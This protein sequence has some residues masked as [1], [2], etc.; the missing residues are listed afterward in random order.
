MMIDSCKF[1]A[2]RALILSGLIL[3]I[4]AGLAL[5][6]YG[7]MIELPFLIVKYGGSVL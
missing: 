4:P 7:Y 3:V 5:R 1:Y 6:R 2:S